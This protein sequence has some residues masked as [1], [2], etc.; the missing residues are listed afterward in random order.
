[1]PP[2]E[3]GGDDT[4]SLVC[5]INMFR[6]VRGGPPRRF[7]PAACAC[8]YTRARLMRVAAACVRLLFTVVTL[9]RLLGVRVSIRG[10]H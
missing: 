7:L 8:L 3:R 1:M 2:A 9:L 6:L 10:G 5:L 4:R